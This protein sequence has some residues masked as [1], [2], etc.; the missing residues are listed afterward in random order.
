MRRILLAWM[1]G[2][3]AVGQAVAG[4]PPTAQP[5]IGTAAQSALP[6]Q[7]LSVLFVGNSYT[8]YND[9]PQMVRQMSVEAA[10]PRPL[11]VRDVTFGGASLQAH[12]QRGEVQKVIASQ[13]WDYVVI[14]DF[15]TMPVDDPDLTRE[16][17]RH[18]AAA[19]R[20][21]GAQPILYLTWARKAKPAMQDQLDSVYTELANETHA[22]LAP[23]GQAWKRALAVS[24]QPNLFI[25]DGSHPSYAG[26]Y[27]AAS[28]FYSLI[29]GV[30]PPAPSAEQLVKLDHT[31]PGDLQGYAWSSI[32]AQDLALRT[33]PQELRS[34]P[35]T[36]TR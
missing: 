33:V 31:K 22:L 9:L 32:Q 11:Q 21:A 14:Q 34:L 24:P 12:W 10:Q 6:G 16:Y 15:S 35:V 8:F 3:A 5:V 28:V 2:V 29:Y 25:E 18:V 30:Q 26:S 23:V 4:D 19:A 27:L 17:V 1:L 20:K 36:A 7:P 13:H